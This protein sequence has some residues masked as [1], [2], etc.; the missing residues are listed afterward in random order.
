MDRQ[1]RKA[2]EKIQAR[3]LKIAGTA[4]TLM[5]WP[6]FL[7]WCQSTVDAYNARPHRGLAKTR[8]AVTGKVRHQSPDEVWAAAE[9]AGWEPMRVRED[10]LAVLL[11]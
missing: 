4:P 1:A 6:E 2:T 3:H 9:L 11:R 7:T 10:E 5:P 8:D